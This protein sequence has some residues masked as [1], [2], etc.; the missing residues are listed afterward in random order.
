MYISKVSLVNYRNFENAFFLFNKGINTI[1]GENASGKT[2]LFRAIRLI[3]DDSLLSSA[4]KLNEN[5]FNRNLKSW[6]G[7]W[8]IISLEFNEISNDE[9]IQSLFI[10]G[11]GVVEGDI[12]TPVTTDFLS[13]PKPR[14][15]TSSP[16]WI[17]PASIR[18][19]A[20]VP[21]PV[22]ENTSS[23]GIKKGLS[24]SRGGNGIQVSTASI[25]SITLSSH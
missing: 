12:S 15:S 20:T 9:A 11:S 19:V 17:I 3:L 6:K 25:N 16:T 14:I 10:Y 22:I 1:I 7:K 18:P 23:T 5:D 24:I 8:I 4:Y 2:N 21:R 13:S